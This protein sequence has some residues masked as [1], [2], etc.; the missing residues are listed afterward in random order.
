V[1]V[2]LNKQIANRIF[3]YLVLAALL[4]LGIWLRWRFIHTVHLYPDEFVTLLAIKMIAETGW[5]VMP[6]GL[7]YEHGLLFSYFGSLAWQAD[8][9]YLAVRYTS[10]LF[11]GLALLLTFWVG[12]RWFSPWVGLI[13]TA[14]LVIAPMAVHWSGRARMYALLQLLVLLTLWLAYE[15]L[16]Q[17]KARLRQT[18]LLAYLGALLAH[19]VAVTLAPALVLAAGLFGWLGLGAKTPGGTEAWEQEGGEKKSRHFLSLLSRG[20]WWLELLALIAVLVVAFLVKRAGQP[21]GIEALEANPASA[22][23]GL[24]Q[25]FDIYSDFSLNPVEGWQTIWPFYFSL[26][27]LI[28]TPFALLAVIISL[29]SIRRSLR[30]KA[31]QDPLDP[32]SGLTAHSAVT[33]F[34]GLIL[35]MTT[36]E[37][38]FLVSPDRRDDKYLFMLLPILFLLGAQGITIVANWLL[39]SIT[40]YP[41]TA[42]G[43]QLPITLI[44]TLSI[45]VATWPQ[46]QALLAN[47]GD[48]YESAFAYVRDHWQAGDKILTGTPA[49][50]VFYLG[51][52]DFYSVQR[53]GGYDY[54]VLAVAGQAQPVDRWLAS[55]VIRTE[56][57]LHQ[58]LANH[59]VWLVLERWGLQREYYDLPFQQQLFAQ[60]EYVTEA[61][62]IVV[63]YSKADPRPI[64]PSPAHL[65]YAANSEAHPTFDDLIQLTGYTAE[66]D[67]GRAGQPL[68]LTLYWQALAPVPHDYTV[69]VH[70]RQAEGATV[71]QADHRPLGNLYPTSLWPVGELIRESSELELPSDL[72][73]GNYDLW[74]GFYLLGTGERLPVRDDT[75][76]ENAV[77]LGN[78]AVT[79]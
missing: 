78:L 65:V 42:Q 75:S 13:A 2:D 68:R 10:L 20:Q 39:K 21:K 9:S 25:V 29:I 28:F 8:A 63:L 52:N 67:Q 4:V 69:F 46:T 72:P 55:P 17:N 62:G 27:A 70:L 71:A 74:V 64:A 38:I 66:P 43:G 30:Q 35:L 34:L 12:Q 60:T 18:A 41:W 11:G 76:G 51:R 47:T 23:A 53:R 24:V 7:F 79:P 59:D 73:A 36:L 58:T 22:A 19:F 54:R 5:P 1:S 16:S 45:L 31:L 56:A 6:S 32:S 33:L 37:M 14:G 49:A 3:F 26:P 15:G 61:Q 40:N 44:I 48:D 57:D 77:R 50:A